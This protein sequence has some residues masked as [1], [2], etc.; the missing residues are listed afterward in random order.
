M[1]LIKLLKLGNAS[2]PDGVDNRFLKESVQ[3]IKLPHC[4]LFNFS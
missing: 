2:G 3:Q 4:D 1:K